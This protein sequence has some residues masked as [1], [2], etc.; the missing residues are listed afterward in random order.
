ML[1]SRNRSRSLPRVLNK[2]LELFQKHQVWPQRIM[3][4]LC[5]SRDNIYLCYKQI[6]F[7][8][9]LGF[10]KV[11]KASDE[12]GSVWKHPNASTSSISAV[13]LPVH[14]PY[15]SCPGHTQAQVSEVGKS[16]HKSHDAAVTRWVWHSCSTSSHGLLLCNNWDLVLKIKKG[17]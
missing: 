15:V 7:V 17:I 12:Q 8:L 2:W 10:V 6:S 1:G 5:T 13:K 3:A 11:R 14:R 4:D 16:P 9:H